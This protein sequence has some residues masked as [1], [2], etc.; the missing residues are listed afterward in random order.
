MATTIPKKLYVT[1]QYRKDASEGLLGFASPYTKDAAFEK[2]KVTQD[3]W[4]YGRSAK[5]TIDAN[6]EIIGEFNE[7]ATFR[8]TKLDALMLFAAGCYPKILDNVPLEGF[9][10]SKNV[11]RSGGWSGPGNVLWRIADP[12]G[13]ELEISSENLAKILDCTTIIDGVIQGKCT[14]GRDGSKNILLPEASAPYKEANELTEL[15]DANITIKDIT[16]GDTVALLNTNVKK[17]PYIYL[18][19]FKVYTTSK[20]KNPNSSRYYVSGLTHLVTKGAT[21]Y[22][23]KDTVD[24]KYTTTGTPKI[25]KVL[26]KT[27]QALD[28][29]AT[30]LEIMQTCDGHID[31][32]IDV[33]TLVIDSKKTFSK[34]KLSFKLVDSAYK[35]TGTA[36]P[37]L[38]RYSSIGELFFTEVD[39]KLYVSSNT[40]YYDDN[41]MRQYTSKLTEVVVSDLDKGTIR[42][43][44]NLQDSG[45]Y[46]HKVTKLIR[47]DITPNSTMIF[48]KLVLVYDGV[49]YPIKQAGYLN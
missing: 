8:G 15:I 16:P 44:G 33:V 17:V 21:R 35:F 34:D 45:S 24:G 46:W 41:G 4:A 36:F 38:G 31:N 9:E 28:V 26:N 19:S 12:R 23:F 32:I 3:Q 20:E 22:I 6:D 47:K 1:I 11:R 48:K 10:I 18:G 13:Y 37:S 7:D 30:A 14:W 25:A 5:F 27:N 2:R 39:G 42:L 29:S 43:K 49:N 40:S